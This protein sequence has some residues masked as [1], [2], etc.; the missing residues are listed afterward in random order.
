LILVSG[1]LLG[2]APTLLAQDSHYWTMQY[3]P[4]SSLLGGAVLGSVEDVSG[5]YYNPGALGLAR[6]LTF[7][8]SANV[9]EYSGIALE[10]GGG[11]GVDLGTSS[12]GLRPSLVAGTIKAG[13]F[14]S[15][16]LAY[17]ALTRMMGSQDLAGYAILSGAQ[18]PTDLQLDNLAGLVQYEGEFSDVWAGLT[19]SHALGSHFGLGVT[20]YGAFRSQRRRGETVTQGIGSD[21]SGAAV[22]EIAGGK[23]STLRTLFKLGAYGSVGPVTGGLTVTTP[24]VH[25]TGS[26]QLGVNR[27]T[28]GADTAA[29]AA[30]IQTDLPARFKSPLSVGFGGAWRIGGA[31]IHASAEWYDA[32]AQYVVIQ[33]EDFVSQEPEE[34]VAVDAVQQLDEVFNWGAGVEHAFSSRVS[35]YVSYYTDN[36]GLTD[37][38]ERASLSA[39]PIDIQTITAGADFTVGS[40][41]FTLGIGYG[42]GRKID[43]LL[44]SALRQEDQEFEATFVYRSVKAIFGFE[45]G[46]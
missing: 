7:A 5:T 46:I 41:R 28:F 22:L 18:I 45:I 39:L 8:V 19:Y 40:A 3:G 11:Q 15:G 10:D 37:Q 17:S 4:R 30:S 33:G 26:G 32:I 35:G 34:V 31:R 23:Y 36:S 12:S 25:I 16:V 42:W 9:F 43:E 38:V 21:G 20:W 14:G 44:T 1:A 27:G 24:G 29:L 2:L 6:D 13:L